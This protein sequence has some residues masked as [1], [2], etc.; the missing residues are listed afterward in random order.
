M[1]FD[2]LEIITRLSCWSIEV[3][4]VNLIFQVLKIEDGTSLVTSL[5]NLLR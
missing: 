5:N 1:N 3:K 4:L 2:L